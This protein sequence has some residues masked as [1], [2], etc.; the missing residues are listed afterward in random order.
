MN[1]NK[2]KKFLLVLMLG[3]VAFLINSGDVYATNVLECEYTGEFFGANTTFTIKLDD[4]SG[5]TRSSTRWSLNDG[6]G[7]DLYSLVNYVYSEASKNGYKSYINMNS[8]INAYSLV[9]GIYKEKIDAKEYTQYFV[10]G[11]KWACPS[12]LTMLHDNYGNSNF[13]NGG[14]NG[15]WALFLTVDG[16]PIGENTCV[17]NTIIVGNYDYVCDDHTDENP[18]LSLSKTIYAADYKNQV[19]QAP[20]QATYNSSGTCCLYKGDGR[21]LYVYKYNNIAGSSAKSY[22][23]CVGSGCFTAD[24]TNSK[25]AAPLDSSWSAYHQL[26]DCGQMPPIYFKVENGSYVFSSTKESGYSTATVQTTRCDSKVYDATSSSGNANNNSRGTV[27]T[28]PVTWDVKESGTINI[29]DSPI[30]CEGLLGSD[31]LDDINTVLSWVR[32][33]VPILLVLLGT[34][35]FGKAVLADDDKA[36]SKATRTFIMRSIAAI[37][38]FFAPIIIMY[39]LRLIDGMADGCDIT[40]L[41]VMLWKI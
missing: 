30:D 40:E 32:I 19:I 17:N 25:V 37:A 16:E 28:Q 2:T 7:T 18:K 13:L 31:V 21:S 8:S 4:K 15:N 5:F 12:N 35:D 27:T 24:P 14:Y 22:A 9:N 39:L 36:L 20:S 34:L 23:V 33:G 29:D 3:I 11:D 38:V 26:S 1:F 41:G 10:N 6:S